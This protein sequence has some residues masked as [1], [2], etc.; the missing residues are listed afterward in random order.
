MIAKANSAT[1]QDVESCVSNEEVAIR[2]PFLNR[3][4]VHQKSHFGGI[5]YGDRSLSE[6]GSRKAEEDLT[7]LK[8]YIP[9]FQKHIFTWQ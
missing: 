1:L 5:A 8:L 9:H 6:Y 7:T 2:M 4:I 3:S